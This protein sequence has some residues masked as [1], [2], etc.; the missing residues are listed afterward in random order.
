V[1]AHQP[2]VVSG[3]SADDDLGSLVAWLEGERP[4]VPTVRDASAEPGADD[5]LAAAG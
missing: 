2:F 5:P 3:Q 1:R 4:A